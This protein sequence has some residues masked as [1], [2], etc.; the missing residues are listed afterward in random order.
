MQLGD[1]EFGSHVY[2]YFRALYELRSGNTLPNYQ[3]L[4]R[5]VYIGCGNTY[6]LEMDFVLH[7]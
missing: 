5:K 3:Y 1:S 2:M 7:F 4:F 6:N